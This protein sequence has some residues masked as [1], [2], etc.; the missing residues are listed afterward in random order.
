M[1]YVLGSLAYHD[2]TILK[3][4]FNEFKTQGLS[5]SHSLIHGDGGLVHIPGKEKEVLWYWGRMLEEFMHLPLM[6][7]DK[8]FI[9]DFWNPM[10]V[11]MK[12]WVARMGLQNIKFY[13]IHHGSSQLPGDFASEPEYK[14]WAHYAES[15]WAECYDA[16]F[17]GS[18]VITKLMAKKCSTGKYVTSYL[19]ITSLLPI[20][21]NAEYQKLERVKNTAVMPLR[22]DPDKGVDDFIAYVDSNPNILF[23]AFANE[24]KWKMSNLLIQKPSTRDDLFKIEQQCEYVVSFAKQETF[25]Y[26]VVEA[27][28]NGCKPVLRGSETNCYRELFPNNTFGGPVD[29]APLVQ[30]KYYENLEVPNISWLVGYAEKLITAH[31]SI[32]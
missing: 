4:L 23:M 9:V 31:L 18:E 20:V 32:K 19:P 26:G 29:P 2:D 10:V 27:V 22:M 12:F 15:S 11:Q 14:N 25:G 8:I 6:E 1:I 7:G 3:P 21:R 24:D 13:T 17:C 28:L 5:Y 16:I 30:L